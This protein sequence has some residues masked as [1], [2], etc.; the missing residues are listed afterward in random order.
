MRKERSFGEL[1]EQMLRLLASQEYCGIGFEAPC[2]CQSLPNV[3]SKLR[4]RPES[5]T[6]KVGRGSRRDT[7]SFA[8]VTKMPN[9]AAWPRDGQYKFHCW[10]ISLSL[11]RRCCALPK[12]SWNN[13]A[14]TSKLENWIAERLE[15]TSTNL[16]RYEAQASF[17]P[18]TTCTS[19]KWH[20]EG[21]RKLL[22]TVQAAMR[23][24]KTHSKASRAKP[25][26]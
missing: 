13:E 25:L 7:I 1:V 4:S 6:S 15:R 11:L 23:E 16:Q 2:I 9:K 24:P 19:C 3:G 20:C 12:P 5:S 18:K 8:L 21:D 22:T 26:Q 10:C 17:P 14:P